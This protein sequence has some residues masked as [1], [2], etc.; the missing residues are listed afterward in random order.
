MELKRQEIALDIQEN[1]GFVG[2]FKWTVEALL[3][4]LKNCVEHTPE[5]HRIYLTMT[6]NSIYSE[7]I[8]EDEGPGI[9]DGEKRKIFERFYQ[10]KG[11]PEGNAGIGLALAADL[12]R[13]QNGT[14]KAGNRKGG[15]TRFDIRFYKRVI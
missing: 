8:V 15:G 10:G 12:I 14:V 3:N 11:S 4:I 5:N 9:L 7:I 13:N 6:E 2:D 1:S